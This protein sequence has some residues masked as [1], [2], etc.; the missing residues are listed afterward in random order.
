MIDADDFVL[1]SV[2]E[3]Q[4]RRRV[5][6]HWCFEGRAFGGYTAA[7]ALTSVL[8]AAGRPAAAS[9]S[10]SFLHPAEVGTVEI[11]VGTLRTGRSASAYR[12]VVRQGG[13]IVVDASAWVADA[14]NDPAVT[15]APAPTDPVEPPG[16][17]PSL[18]WLVDDWGALAFADRRAIDYPLTWQEFARGTP[19]V[20]LWTRIDD[21]HEPGRTEPLPSPQVGDVLHA[22]AHLFDAPAQV[23]G[24][25]EVWLLSLD[26]NVTWFPGSMQVRSTDWRQVEVVGAVATGGV[27]AMGMIRDADGN[28]L[29]TMTSQG[30]RRSTS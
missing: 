29:A 24:F 2:D 21:G 1:E 6:K 25:N 5:P 3:G 9:L 15:P 7:L 23:T 19:R 16:S 18:A 20:A 30:L 12:A 10:V 13:A 4:F 27:T 8:Q 11:D 17:L 14:W 28:L 22:D 26:L